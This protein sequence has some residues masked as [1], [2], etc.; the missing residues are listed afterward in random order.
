MARRG[1]QPVTKSKIIG[2]DARCKFRRGNGVL[3]TSAIAALLVAAVGVRWRWMDRRVFSRRG[4]WRNLVGT[5][6]VRVAVHRR[7]NGICMRQGHGRCHGSATDP[8]E[9]QTERKQ[10]VANQACHRTLLYRYDMKTG[11]LRSFRGRRGGQCPA[12]GAL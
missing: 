1:G 12:L 6:F 3:G 8:V 2:A 5:S 11:E 10:H 4:G 9:D 7:R